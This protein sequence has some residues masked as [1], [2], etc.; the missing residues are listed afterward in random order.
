[1]T[2]DAEIDA[3]HDDLEAA[4]DRH[5]TR[6][7]AADPSRLWLRPLE[8]AELPVELEIGPHRYEVIA[9]RAALDAICR[10]QRTDLLG[11]TDSRL[12]TIAVA[13]DQAGAQLRDT[14]LHE[15]LHAIFDYIGL[16]HD[17]GPALEEHVICRLSPAVLELMRR[18]PVLVNYLIADPAAT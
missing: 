5:D 2:N 16:S 18:N 12:N 8:S 3:A 13:P 6:A 17:W 7:L 14:L 10:A 1:M 4:L 15:A 11:H 9:D